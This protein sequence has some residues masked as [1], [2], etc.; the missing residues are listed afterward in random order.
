ML[1]P[2]PYEQ[3]WFPPGLGGPFPLLCLTHVQTRGTLS[4]AWEHVCLSLSI[5]CQRFCLGG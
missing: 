2:Y 1:L 3:S 4:G 5:T